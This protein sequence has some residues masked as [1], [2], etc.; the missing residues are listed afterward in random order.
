[1]KKLLLAILTIITINVSAQLPDGSLAPDWTMTDLNGTV[2]HLY[3]YLDDGYTVFIDFSAV[4]CGPCWSYH[5]SGALEDLYMNH[6]P[7][8]HPNVNANTTDDVMVFFIE[9][10]ESTVAQLNG[11]SGS[12]GNWVTG[13]PYPIIGTDG[14]VNND[15]VTGDYQIGY[16]PTV[17]MICPDRITTETGAV[18]N[19]Y[20]QVG[21]CPPLPTTTN[22]VRTFTYTGPT[23]SC[24]GF[25]V[26]KLTIQNYGTANLTSV[27]I[28]TY[29]GGSVNNVENWTGSLSQFQTEEVTLPA[30]SGLGTVS[31]IMITIEN[32]NSSNDDDPSNNQNISFTA[33]DANAASASGAIS[34]GVITDQY[35]NETSWDIT[36]QYGVVVASGSGYG[37]SGP[38]TVLGS[39]FSLPNGCYT[40]TIYDTY[41]DGICCSYGNGY[42]TIA[43]ASGTIFGGPGSGSFTDQIS[44]SF[45]IGSLNVEENN[46]SNI[47]VYPNPAKDFININIDVLTPNKTE[48][49]VFDVL[50]RNVYSKSLG[51]LNVGEITVNINT[52]KL[53]SGLYYIHVL[54]NNKSEVIDVNLV[55]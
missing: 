48:I 20:G 50:G 33:V 42:Y 52:E 31:N 24:G 5:T 19:P 8:G 53:K 4:W 39:P 3:E 29:V 40:F 10:D 18:S 51:N 11:G 17:Y 38:Q 25:L 45:Q 32:P 14:T 27:D 9:G 28:T 26:P 36:N 22:D 46:F 13:T 41:G 6:G 43:D 12:Q 2:H 15:D 55:K 16:W 7:A 1:M 44:H 34:V 23:S 47:N 37:N 35:G 49:A 54:N 30:L 21:A